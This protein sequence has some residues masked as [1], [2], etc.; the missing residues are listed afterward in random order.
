MF[1][2]GTTL[3][4]RMVEVTMWSQVSAAR[5]KYLPASEQRRKVCP[6]K[7]SEVLQET[8]LSRNGPGTIVFHYIAP[9]NF[10]LI[11]LRNLEIR[12]LEMEEDSPK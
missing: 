8:A 9:S 4:K 10:G 7:G 5:I 12:V 1:A 6:S 11:V 2:D 3:E